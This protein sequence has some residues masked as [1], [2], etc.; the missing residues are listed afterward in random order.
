MACGGVGVVVA[1]MYVVMKGVSLCAGDR[2]CSG[3]LGCINVF[4]W[5]CEAVVLW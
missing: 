3:E 4:F 1:F 5:W 2:R